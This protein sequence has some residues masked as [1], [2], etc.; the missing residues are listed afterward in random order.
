MLPY[1][2]F[3]I[4]LLAYIV[5][6][7]LLNVVVS[8]IAFLLGL[9]IGLGAAGIGANPHATRAIGGLLGAGLGFLSSWLYFAILESSSWQATIGKKAL[10]LVVTDEAG[11]RISFGQATGRYFSKILSGLILGFGFLMIA[12]NDRKQG[13][14]DKIAGTLVYKAR[15][16][17]AA[18][19]AFE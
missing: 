6:W 10:N 2:G 13:L 9:P 14:H 18:I 1:G 17:R 16:F 3:W 8:I 11:G 12:W 19:A 15:D 7:I 5:D 4:R